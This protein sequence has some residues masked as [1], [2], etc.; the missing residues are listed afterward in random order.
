MAIKS[1]YGEMPCE[2]CGKTVVVKIKPELKTL[3]YCCDLCDAAP[4]AKPNPSKSSQ[5]S[6]WMRKIKPFDS[7]DVAPKIDTPRPAP[8]A[9]PPPVAKPA[10]RNP[11]FPGA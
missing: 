8:D 10:A 6:H 11:L 5:Y 3:S 1:N 7:A 2:T 4:Y 9:P